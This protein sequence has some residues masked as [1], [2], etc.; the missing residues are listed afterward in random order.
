MANEGKIGRQ[1][2][3]DIRE[4]QEWAAKHKKQA[5]KRSGSDI[6]EIVGV[7]K[8]KW[9]PKYCS[10]KKVQDFGYGWA[11]ERI[12][13]RGEPLTERN[14]NGCWLLRA[15]EGGNL[16]N[17]GIGEFSA[18]ACPA[19]LEIIQ[20]RNEQ[21]KVRKQGETDDPGLCFFDLGNE[22][23]IRCPGK[24]VKLDGGMTMRA[25]CILV[26]FKGKRDG[27]LFG[28]KVVGVEQHMCALTKKY[29]RENNLV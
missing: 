26:M 18:V 12:Y 24:L 20:R 28:S 5:G 17:F 25:E 16:E 8:E 13:C 22:F 6:H 19:A 7:R 1:R 29:L 23:T 15:A 4:A 11:S 27:T 3:E 9:D 14:P 10:W 2:K 21:E